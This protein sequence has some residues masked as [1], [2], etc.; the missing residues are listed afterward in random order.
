MDKEIIAEIAKS[1]LIEETVQNVA[2]MRLEDD[3]SLKDLCQDLYL[4]LLTKDPEKIEEIYRKGD[5][6]FY[7]TRMVLN[8]LR[9]K[10]SPYF[11]LY[12]KNLPTDDTDL[13]QI[14]NP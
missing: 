7:V 5:M 3:P 11:Y 4:S 12:K 10:N 2:K 1:N 14:P 8:N 13:R 6:R 9:S